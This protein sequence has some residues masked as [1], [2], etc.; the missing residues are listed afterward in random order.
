MYMINDW[1]PVDG[2]EIGLPKPEDSSSSLKEAYTQG[3]HMKPG[4]IGAFVANE[5]F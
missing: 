5:V 2:R 3:S 1:N 4:L